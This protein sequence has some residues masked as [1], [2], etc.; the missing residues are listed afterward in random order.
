MSYLFVKVLYTRMY[1]L[2]LW[3]QND[4]NERGKKFYESILHYN[5]I[6][7]QMRTLYA[8]Q[9]PSLPFNPVQRSATYYHEHASFRYYSKIIFYRVLRFTRTKIFYLQYK[10]SV[11]DLNDKKC[12]LAVQQEIEE[13]KRFVRFTANEGPFNGGRLHTACFRAKRIR[14]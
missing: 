9:S 11:C 2:F 5:D 6:I 14:T 10:T 12:L 13:K 3:K 7:V 8:C 1:V 4:A